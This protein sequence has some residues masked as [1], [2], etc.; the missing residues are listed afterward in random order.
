MHIRETAPAVADRAT[1]I[2]LSFLHTPTLQPLCP[3]RLALCRQQQQRSVSTCGCA[4]AHV[5]HGLNRTLEGDAAADALSQPVTGIF[6]SSTVVIFSFF[7]VR[8]LVSCIAI[9]I[10]CF[11]FFLSSQDSHLHSFDP[12]DHVHASWM[13][14]FFS[15]LLSFKVD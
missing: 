3:S 13:L 7:I 14:L 2:L 1:T 6:I 9:I 10:F 15:Y 11:C 12:A 4:A 5:T 8:S